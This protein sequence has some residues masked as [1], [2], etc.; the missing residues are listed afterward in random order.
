MQ[1]YAF[2]DTPGFEA[3]AAEVNNGGVID[4]SGSYGIG[5]GDGGK[6]VAVTLNYTDATK[7]RVSIT[8]SSCAEKYAFRSPSMESAS[9]APS[10]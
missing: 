10:I 3:D 9:R 6:D 1:D 7:D 2:F 5:S 4:A 8:G